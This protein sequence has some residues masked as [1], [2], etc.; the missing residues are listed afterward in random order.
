M[1]GHR[2]ALVFTLLAVAT[3]AVAVLAVV[4]LHSG[5]GSRSDAV[6][7]PLSA[8]IARQVPASAPFEGLGELNVGIGGRC[9]RLAVADSLTERVAGLRGHT[10]LGP[11]DGMLFVF[12]GPT[13]TAFTM[14]GVTVPLQIGF[15]AADGSR[16]NALLMRPC[17]HKAESQ[18]P[19]YRADAQFLYAV[20]TLK[21]GLPSG[22]VTTCS[23]A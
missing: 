1:H 19:V 7:S 11:Y 15:Y 8:G 13:E 16:E 4:V 9:L 17:P 23:P 2:R 5:D 6:P 12:P 22:P 3:A 18:C 21:G 10:D 14:S 20:E